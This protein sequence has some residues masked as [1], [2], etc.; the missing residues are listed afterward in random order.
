MV[1]LSDVIYFSESHSALLDTLNQLSTVGGANVSPPPPP[2]PPPLIIL[3]VKR[4]DNESEHQ[5]LDAL[6]SA[7]AC[8]RLALNRCLCRSNDSSTVECPP[9]QQHTQ[10]TTKTTAPSTAAAPLHV[11]ELDGHDPNLELY[12]LWKRTGSAAALS[13]TPAPTASDE[14]TATATATAAAPPAASDRIRSI[15]RSFIESHWLLP[16]IDRLTPLHDQLQR[17]ASFDFFL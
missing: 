11:C 15:D 5:F 2:P 10:P 4:R 6:R 3:S 7:F 12:V 17:P 1:V 16:A 9:Q 13:S 14:R 8:Y